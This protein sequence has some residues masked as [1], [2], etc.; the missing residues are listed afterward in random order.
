MDDPP[1]PSTM[2]DER[3]FTLPNEP[4]KVRSA[5]CIP[6]L[7]GTTLLGLLTLMHPDPGHFNRNSIA[8]IMESIAPQMALV[9]DNARLHLNC[10]QTQADLQKTPINQLPDPFE[11]ESPPVSDSSSISSLESSGFYIMTAT[12]KLIYANS[13]FIKIFEYS[14]GELVGLDSI[15]NLVSRD[16]YNVL[17]EQIKWCAAGKTSRFYCTFKSRTKSG[18]FVDLEIEGS[19]ITSFLRVPALIGSLRTI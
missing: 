15:F 4:Y 1:P 11:F 9:L 6:I 18:K 3:W 16:S 13:R 5:L 2:N 19:R 14:L 12:G 7:R 17:I 8:Y 10:A